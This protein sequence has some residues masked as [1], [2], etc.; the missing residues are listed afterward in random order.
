MN[1]S[2]YVKIQAFVAKHFTK[3]SVKH[4]T[5]IEILRRLVFSE[6]FQERF[7]KSFGFVMDFLLFATY[8]LPD[9]ETGPKHE[10]FIC[11]VLQ[12]RNHA[13]VC[14]FRSR[15][16]CMGGF[17]ISEKFSK[18][19]LGLAFVRGAFGIATLKAQN[20]CFSKYEFVKFEA[21]EVV[22]KPSGN[23]IH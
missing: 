6:L 8:I 4:K 15:K 1:A 7:N 17:T 10:K 18:N 19:C 9:I 12:V 22:S 21:T 5:K 14:C 3:L 20:K 2:S 11:V 23:S 13:S 16:H